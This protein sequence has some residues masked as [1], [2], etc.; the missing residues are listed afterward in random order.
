MK[1]AGLWIKGNLSHRF[2]DTAV[3]FWLGSGCSIVEISAMLGDTVTV[4][5]KHYRKL[6][7]QRLAERLAKVPVRSCPL[8]GCQRMSE[9]LTV[10]EVALILKCSED[11]VVR[12]F[13]KM[14]GVIDLGRSETRDRRRYR[15]LRVPKAILGNY[16]SKKAGRSV[17]VTV[18]DRPERRRKSANWKAAAVLNLAKAGLQ[19]GCRNKEVYRRLANTAFVLAGTNV[20][21]SMWAEIME[22][23]EWEDEQRQV[24]REDCWK[25]SRRC[26]F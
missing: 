19:N 8:V 20:P 24:D 13:A 1:A 16:L 14:D 9:L 5:E 7:S 18:P 17:N 10:S 26:S 2:R 11:A 12:R 15:V 22:S 6:M 4:V 3:D 25:L 21:E 23:Y